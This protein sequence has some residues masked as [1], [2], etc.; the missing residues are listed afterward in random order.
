[1]LLS[2]ELCLCFLKLRERVGGSKN[3]RDLATLNV[4]D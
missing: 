2:D 4:A 1:M 3:R